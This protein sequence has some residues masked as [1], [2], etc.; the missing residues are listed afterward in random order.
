VSVGEESIE[1]AASEAELLDDLEE[2]V[3]GFD[4]VSEVDPTPVLLDEDEQVAAWVARSERGSSSAL[5]ALSAYQRAAEAH[6]TLGPEDQIRLASEYQDLMRLKKRL[7]AGDLRGGEERRARDQVR[8]MDLMMERLTSSCW[9]LA[10]LIVRENAEGRFGRDKASEMLPDL[11]SEANMALVE[12]VRQF[13]PERT[14]T[15]ATYAARVV[16]DHVRMVISR[17]GYIH[18]APSWSRLKRIASARVPELTAEL[19]RTPSK[20]EVQADLL[21]TCL[22][23]AERKLTDDQRKLPDAQRHDVKMAKLRKQGMLGALRDIDEVMA[24]TQSV[25][26]LDQPVG[27][28]GGATLADLLPNQSGGGLFDSVELDELKKAIASALASLTERERT[29][30]LLRYG[31]VD[32]ENWTYA[33][34][35]EK[36]DVTPERIRQIER[37]VM[38]KLSSPHGQYSALSSFLPS[39]FKEDEPEPEPARR[40]WRR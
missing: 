12:A 22:A 31:F 17:D 13:D 30:I 10:W 7:E 5:S 38:G 23:W 6:G 11:M 25:A 4:D 3:D 18:L 29:I 36:Y 34:I 20:E 9:R 24:V 19:G 27:D 28:D 40:S 32:G 39:Q 37:A 33:A 15:F 35:A 1:K 26:S 14:P 8:R 21:Q 16:R 2:V